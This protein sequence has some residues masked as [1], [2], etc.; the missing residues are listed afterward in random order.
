MVNPPQTE[1]QLLERA[2]SLAGLSLFVLKSRLKNFASR[3]ITAKQNAKEGIN[4]K[5]SPIV[6][7]IGINTLLTKA[8]LIR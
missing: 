3:N 7:A 1:Q 5:R 8:R 2:Q 4:K 6:E